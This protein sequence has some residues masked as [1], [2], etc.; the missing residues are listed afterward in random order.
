MTLT[1]ELYN[2]SQAWA[3][4]K[5][6]LYPFLKEALQAGRIWV[7]EVKLRKRTSKQNRRYWGNGILAQIATQATAGG[8]LYSA[9][10]WHEV[11]KQKF[12]GVEELPNGQVIGKSSTGLSTAEFCEF[13]DQVEAWAATELGVCFVDLIPHEVSK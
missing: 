12:I 13:S 2:R 3:A 11:A 10:S 8:K 9:E 4:I 7:L 1:I 5:D 6:K